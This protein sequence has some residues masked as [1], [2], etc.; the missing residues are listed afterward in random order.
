MQFDLKISEEK[1]QMLI[2]KKFPYENKI[3]L[4]KMKISNPKIILKDNSNKIYVSSDIKVNIFNE[5]DF[6]TSSL[7][8]GVVKFNNKTN[9]FFLD[10][11]KIEKL[12]TKNL[13]KEVRLLVINNL[14]RLAKHIL[15]T[16]AIYH[17]EKEEL[18]MIASKLDI[19]KII[20]KDKNMIITLKVL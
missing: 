12:N 16:E 9:D 15:K 20:V 10:D 19:Q 11:F 2:D 7:L 6:N 13:S 18:G 3:F 14:E 4:S 17:L 1:L 8:S 5:L